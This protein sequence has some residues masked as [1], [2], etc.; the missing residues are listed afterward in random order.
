MHLDDYNCVLCAHSVEENR[1][2]LFLDF[3][4]AQQCWSLIQLHIGPGDPQQT[5]LELKYQ[6]RVPLFMDVIILMCWAIWM[7]RNDLIFRE[8]QPS[9]QDCKQHFEKEFALAML[10]AKRD[11]PELMDIWINARI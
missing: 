11:L 7:V 3:P 2:H 8:L 5:L 4:F 9:M 6:L 1:N 10:R